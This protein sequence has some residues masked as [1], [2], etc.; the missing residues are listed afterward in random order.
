VALTAVLPAVVRL[1]L[2]PVQGLVSRQGVPIV[3]TL[4]CF[5]R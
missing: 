2:L 5:L 4:I 1:S 3:Y